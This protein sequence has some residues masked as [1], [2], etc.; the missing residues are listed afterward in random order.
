MNTWD[1]FEGWSRLGFSIIK[2]SRSTRRNDDGIPLF[3]NSQV[4]RN[5]VSEPDN[6]VDYLADAEFWAKAN[7]QALYRQ[8][9]REP[10]RIY[11]EKA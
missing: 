2:H 4:R 11:S 7:P 6:G 9:L 3:H 5:H 1:T 8:S 10:H